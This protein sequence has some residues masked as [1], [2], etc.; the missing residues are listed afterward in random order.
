MAAV[1]GL[2]LG[3]TLIAGCFS[4]SPSS[5]TA[6]GRS[7]G[8]YTVRRGDTLHRIAQR[9]GVSV[10]GL[11]TANHIANPRSL[12]VG[13]V[14]AIPGYTSYAAIDNFGFGNHS[15][16]SLDFSDEHPSRIFVWPVAQG[17]IS[18]GY[19]IRNG[20]MH[21]GVDIAAPLGTPVHAAESGTVIYAG[22]LRGYGNVIIVRHDDHYVTV[23]GHNSENLVHEG[24]AVR[25]GETICEIGRTGHTTGAN[26][27]FEVRRDNVARNPLAY[28]P[29][30]DQTAGISFARNT[31][32]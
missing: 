6:G 23:Y 24:D 15:E 13:Q 30:P 1:L 3:G 29:R 26:L 31:G 12:E 16:S 20:T 5:S 7:Q 2:A 27:H 22:R 11:M 4:S 21:D 28:L 19:G 32:G 18:S 14:L 17:T 9:Y 8:T 10:A 25:C